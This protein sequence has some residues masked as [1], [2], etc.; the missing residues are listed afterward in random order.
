MSDEQ[1]KYM[2]RA[3]AL[4]ARASLEDR[5]GGVFGAVVVKDGIIVGE[6]WNRVIAQ[7]DPTWHAETSAIRAACSRLGTFD[8]SGATIYTSGEPC[9]M[10]LS[11]IYWAHIDK[12]YYAATIGDALEYGGF[13]D[14]F[15]YEQFTKPASERKIPQQELLRAEGVEVWKKYAAL[16]DKTPY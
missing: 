2:R 9:P 1:N 4:S 10:C 7:N 8:L 15:I 5:S 12:I 11:A 3:I 14:S 13:D 6:G 16:P